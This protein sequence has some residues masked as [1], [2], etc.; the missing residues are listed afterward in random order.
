MPFYT[1]LR[2]PGGKG[3]LGPWLARLIAHNKL[4]DGTYV[5]PYAGGC[6][7]AMHLLLEGHIRKIV[8]NDADPAIHSFWWAVLNDS[9]ELTRR[10]IHCPV[11]LEERERQQSILV[12]SSNVS[13]TDLGFSAFFLNRTNRSGILKGGVI[14]GKAQ[15]GKYRLDARFNRADLV[16]RISQ[17]SA[18]RDK[19]ELFGLDAMS[20][21]DHLQDTLTM[22]SLVYLDPP[23]FMKGSQLYRNFYSAKDHASIAEKVLSLRTPWLVTYDKCT[24]IEEL[25]RD[26]AGLTFSPYYSTHVARPRA[27]EL[28]FFGNLQLQAEPYLQRA[29]PG[30]LAKYSKG[31]SYQAAKTVALRRLSDES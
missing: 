6:G 29:N 20:L 17:I 14:G 21:L 24:A 25:Y 18:M 26:A 2:Y 9:K 13:P 1:P 10:I 11:T 12:N 30:N 16:Q 5:E 7:A 23:Y 8:I 15:D 27:S 4:S 3:Q 31:L 28:M 19:I 22:K